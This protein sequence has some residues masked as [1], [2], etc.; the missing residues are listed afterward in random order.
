MRDFVGMERVD[1]QTKQDLI[2]FSFHLTVGNMDEAYRAVKK[3]SSESIWEN[4]AHMCVKTKRMDV[5]E[6]CL[7]NMKDARG[8]QAVREAMKEP[9]KDAQ[10][11]MVAIQLGLLSDAERLYQECGRWDLLAKLYQ[12]SGRWMDA[13]R[14]CAKNDRIHLKT[15]HYLYAKHLEALGD[16][17]GAMKHYEKSETHRR[18]VPRMLYDSQK[19]EDLKQY[20]TESNEPELIK[21]W[22]QHCESKGDYEQALQFYSR[23]EETLA[24][25]RVHCFRSKQVT[26]HPSL[27]PSS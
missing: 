16:M 1:E 6:V 5:A 18:E 25:V 9:E 24:L 19:L 27:T 23:A 26:Q 3:I 11:A 17:R 20:I 2:N 4:M 8:A 21:W 13:L 15:T 10:V 12:A 14:L 7:G 22:A